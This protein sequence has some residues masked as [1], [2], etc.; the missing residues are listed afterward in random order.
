MNSEGKRLL[1]AR[2]TAFKSGD[3]SAYSVARGIRSAK[4]SYKLRIEEDF[5]SNSNPWRMWQGIQSI[6]DYKR[7]NN[8]QHAPVNNTANLA[9]ELNNF[10][11]RFDKDNNQ[12]PVSFKLLGDPQTLVLHTHEV[13]R[14][15]RRINTQKAVG[16]DGLK[17]V[18]N[19]KKWKGP[20]MERIRQD[21]SQ[22]AGQDEESRRGKVSANTKY[23]STHIID[24]MVEII[25]PILDDH[26]VAELSKSP[27]WGLMVDETTDIS[28]TKQLGLVVRQILMN[29]YGDAEMRT[30]A[31]Q[32]RRL[33]ESDL[34][35]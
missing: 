23:T 27:V 3:T 35:S 13:Q 25:G 16:P 17:V 26:L 34:V 29:E 18:H 10:F 33:R 19:H 9:G 30:L 24:E 4:L 20:V 14:A 21:Q 1:K 7:K 6:T 22:S 28:V 12:P 11:A 8:T 32:F 5:N 2:D 15:L 31:E